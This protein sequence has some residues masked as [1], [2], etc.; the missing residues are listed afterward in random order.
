MAK[1]RRTSCSVNKKPLK[2]LRVVR[3]A[4]YTQPKS[5]VNESRWAF[6]LALVVMLSQAAAFGLGFQAEDIKFP[7]Y[8]QAHELTRGQTNRLKLLI[9]SKTAERLPNSTYRLGGMYLQ[10]QDGFGRTNLIAS[11]PECFY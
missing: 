10:H 3:R 7:I 5:G 4:M 2:R 1:S 9:T 11:S 8:Y 6:R